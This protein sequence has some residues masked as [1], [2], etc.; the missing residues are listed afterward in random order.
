ME[1]RLNNRRLFQLT[2][3]LRA[4]V[5]ARNASQ[6]GSVLLAN[7]IERLIEGRVLKNGVYRAKIPSLPESTD[8]FAAAGVGVNLGQP[9]VDRKSARKRVVENSRVWHGNPPG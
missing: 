1:R 7:L 9:E 4:P 6:L 3:L 2:L 8:S 5:R